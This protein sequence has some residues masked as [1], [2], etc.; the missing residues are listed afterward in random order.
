MLLNKTEEYG[1]CQIQSYQINHSKSYY[2]V[3][4]LQSFDNY[5]QL[6]KQNSSQGLLTYFRFNNNEIPYSLGSDSG[7]DNN[8]S[9]ENN[10]SLTLFDIYGIKNENSISNL[11]GLIDQISQLANQNSDIRIP[12]L[13]ATIY[14]T[15]NSGQQVLLQIN[16]EIETQLMSY[17]LDQI[18]R[19]L[20]FSPIYCIQYF[21]NLSKNK[22]FKQSNPFFYLVLNFDIQTF[23]KY[24][25]QSNQ[26]L[27]KILALSVSVTLILFVITLLLSH[28]KLK[29]SIVSFIDSIDWTI[30]LMN[31]I[32]NESIFDSNV[33]EDFINDFFKRY[34]LNQEA[35]EL[36]Q[37]YFILILNLIKT[38]NEYFQEGQEEA[39]LQKYNEAYTLFTKLGNQSGIGIC[40]NNIGNIHF[41]KENYVE[42]CLHYSKSY[43]ISLQEKEYITSQ[44]INHPKQKEK[45]DQVKLIIAVRAFQ[46]AQTFQHVNIIPNEDLTSFQTQEQ[47]SHLQ[48]TNTR[49]SNQK[50]IATPQ[51]NSIESQINQIKSEAKKSI[52][53]TKHNKIEFDYIIEEEKKQGLEEGIN[54]EKQLSGLHL[55]LREKQISQ[56][57]IQEYFTQKKVK[58]EIFIK[59]ANQKKQQQQIY[60]NEQKIQIS[61]KIS[62]LNEKSPSQLKI[63]DNQKKYDVAIKYFSVAYEYFNQNQTKRSISQVT[64]IC[65]CMAECYLKLKKYSHSQGLITEARKKLQKCNQINFQKSILKKNIQDVDSI[66]SNHLVNSKNQ[67]LNFNQNYKNLFQC[68]QISTPQHFQLTQSVQSNQSK[69]EKQKNQTNK[70]RDTFF[71]LQSPILFKAALQNKQFLK[72]NFQNFTVSIQNNIL[73]NAKRQLSSID[74]INNILEKKNFRRI[75]RISSAKLTFQNNN[76]LKQLSPNSCKINFQKCPSIVCLDNQNIKDTSNNIKQDG[77]QQNY[78]EKIT[79]K[80]KIFDTQNRRD[81][82]SFDKMVNE[83]SKYQNQTQKHNYTDKN[84]NQL[85]SYEQYCNAH[86]GCD[87]KQ[88]ERK[89]N[90]SI[91]QYMSSQKQN[92]Q[93]K[94]SLFQKIHNSVEYLNGIDNIIQKKNQNKTENDKKSEEN[95][96]KLQAFPVYLNQANKN[97]ND[98]QQYKFQKADSIQIEQIQEFYNTN[99]IKQSKENSA[100]L[101]P[102]MSYQN[103]ARPFLNNLEAKMQSKLNKSN[104]KFSQSQQYA[105]NHTK[106]EEQN[107]QQN[108]LE[109]QKGKQKKKSL[110]NF[111]S[112]KLNVFLNQNN[113][114]TIQI[115]DISEISNNLQNKLIFDQKDELFL[116]YSVLQMKISLVQGKFYKSQGERYFLKAA[117]QFIEVLEYF[118]PNSQEDQYDPLD[119]LEAMKELLYIFQW[120]N[121][122]EQALQISEE[123]NKM[124]NSQVIK[125]KLSRPLFFIDS[126]I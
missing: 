23:N 47:A 16:S 35:K 95:S 17:S 11:R 45:L 61:N 88:E 101:S 105:N 120:Y 68:N 36:L 64:Y 113:K 80:Q 48:N 37:T 87:E 116:P 33:N 25:N 32:S 98:F 8:N 122:Q 92:N 52:F 65:I 34:C 59:Q 83:L 114:N 58:S 124:E 118:D 112:E 54:Y 73:R 40:L 72:Q 78:I 66:L 107:E 119:K 102:N 76:K 7:E 126:F 43:Q 20:V 63:K 111:I 108:V 50:I 29:K 55:N 115:Q 41:K 27:Q 42:A 49:Q 75:K 6:T 28:F 22:S 69:K 19:V 2:N 31:I 1:T 44:M 99:Q 57:F 85:N 3:T 67:K 4:I 103:T 97:E 94:S 9:Q 13:Y 93:A 89:R 18:F 84:F 91:D 53:Q 21:K 12:Q 125:E 79:S 71:E 109:K 121:C 110:L 46:I 90:I 96:K 60:G 5:Q 123:I 117:S 39:A 24:T 86:Q 30:E 10:N 81:F 14:D 70:F 106:Q 26:D 62:C 100:F 15:S 104:D 74:S 56:E 38:A 51:I 77:T 82:K